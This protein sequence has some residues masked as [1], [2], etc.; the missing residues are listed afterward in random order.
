MAV[1]NLA[2]MVGALTSG[3]MFDHLGYRT[4]YFV[5]AAA[6]VAAAGGLRG[7]DGLGQAAK[8]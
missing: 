4:L 8:V 1:I 7:G 5:L 3:W 6:S 2:N